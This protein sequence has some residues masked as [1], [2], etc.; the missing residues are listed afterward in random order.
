MNLFQHDASTV[1]LKISTITSLK[2]NSNYKKN[3]SCPYMSTTNYEQFI[4]E[5]FQLQ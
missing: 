4:L 1:F 3:K 5:N 2:T